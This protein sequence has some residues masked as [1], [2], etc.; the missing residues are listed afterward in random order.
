MPSLGAQ[1]QLTS[2]FTKAI[3]VPPP[4]PLPLRKDMGSAWNS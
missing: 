4:L 2:R 3:D 1:T